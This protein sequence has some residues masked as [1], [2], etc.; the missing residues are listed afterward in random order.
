MSHEQS[1]TIERNGK[2]I[3]VFGRDLPQAGQQL[4]DS[5]EFNTMEDAI[6]AAVKRSESFNQPANPPS[7]FEQ[8][9][10]EFQQQQRTEGTA[11]EFRP[12][13]FVESEFAEFNRRNN[14]EQTQE[15]LPIGAT[16]ASL[17]VGLAT[18]AATRSPSLAREAAKMAGA[19]AGGEFVQNITELA[20]GADAAPQSREELGLRVAKE[21]A[22]GGA[23][24]LGGRGVVALGKKTGIF[25]FF[26]STMTPEAEEAFDF[27]KLRTSDGRTIGDIAGAEEP[28]LL[29]SQATEHRGLDILNNV[30]EHSLFGGGPL[31]ARRLAQDKEHG[32]LA[33]EFLDLIAPH[34]DDAQAARI[35]VASAKNNKQIQQAPAK[36]L[37]NTIEHEVAPRTTDGIQIGGI[38]GG[39]GALKTFIQK[40]L[41]ISGSLHGLGDE[42]VG[43][44]MLRKIAEMPDQM[45][46]QTIIQ[47]RRRL[48]GIREGFEASPDTR[49]SPAVGVFK[50]LERFADQAVE[51]ALQGQGRSDL[52]GMWRQANEIWKNG[53]QRFNNGIIRRV[54]K[55]IDLDK[56][57]PED[58]VTTAFAPGKVTRMNVMKEAVS[59]PAWQNIARA[60]MA[61]IYEKA[62]DPASGALLGQSL[63]QALIGPEGLGA[64]GLTTAVGP[65]VAQRWLQF[66][67]AVKTRQAKSGAS[68][69][70]VFIQL[71]QSGAAVQ[72]SQVAIAALGLS[73]GSTELQVGAGFILFGPAA[74]ARIMT[75][76]RSARILIEGVKEDSIT[77]FSAQAGTL[78]RLVAGAVPRTVPGVQPEAP[79]P[80]PNTPVAL[81]GASRR[82]LSQLGNAVTR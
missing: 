16:V 36:A 72:A 55:M 17:G 49:K 58:I 43:G 19:S 7:I 46:V 34:I 73:S 20:L 60:G 70:S 71:T 28:F 51:R 52:V 47:L 4:P 32:R 63:E 45:N 44:P 69:G 8:E 9:F 24:E 18:F 37:Y 80:Q 26:K 5:G 68:E 54:S 1:E 11:R 33:E 10:A 40:E 50:Q 31:Q 29:P 67:R 39:L 82:S 61:K 65:I 77:K 57:V 59:G 35:F 42:T 22:I 81:P 62:V 48:R 79:T 27:F 15:R 3:N 25:N 74:V 41:D 38:T 14:P 75:N 78:A 13:Q 2:F 23:A 12:G 30:A 76:P 6:K 64:Q 56:S 53:S 21:G 66:A